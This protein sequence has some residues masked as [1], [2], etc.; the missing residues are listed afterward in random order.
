M[1]HDDTLPEQAGPEAGTDG[2]VGQKDKTRDC[3]PTSLKL[4]MLGG[5]DVSRGS[6]TGIPPQPTIRPTCHASL[7][8]D[9]RGVVK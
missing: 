9:L 7:W 1:A 3:A 8:T 2:K 5:P 4:P 6:K